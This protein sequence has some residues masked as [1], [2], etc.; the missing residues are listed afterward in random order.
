M[1]ARKRKAVIDESY[2]KLDE[3]CIWLHEFFSS[4]RKAGFNNDNALWII[5][6]PESYPEW[7]TYK[8]PT[9]ADIQKYLDEEEE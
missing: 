5:A 4:L 7:I 9:V 8:K 3:H 1:A 6:S 2:S